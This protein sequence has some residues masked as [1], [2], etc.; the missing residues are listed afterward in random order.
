MR[1]EPVLADVHPSSLRR[2]VPSPCPGHS[3]HLDAAGAGRIGLHGRAVDLLGGEDGPPGQEP[4]GHVL[5]DLVPGRNHRFGLVRRGQ[6][7]QEQGCPV[8]LVV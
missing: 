3:G 5:D 6:T 4:L 7:S 1:A 2:H 8:A